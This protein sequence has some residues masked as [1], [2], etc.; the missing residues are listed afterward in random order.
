MIDVVPS[1]A[2]VED[3]LVR[4]QAL[5]V[6]RSFIVRA[7]AGSGK[8]RLLIQRYLGLLACVDEPEEIVAITFT[9]KAA[10]EMRERVLRAFAN[11]ELGV[12]EDD[13]TR[14]LALAALARDRLRGWQLAANPSRLR[15]QTI[16]ALNAS[17]TRQMPLAARFGAQP[18]SID[19]ASHLYDEAARALLAEI[20]GDGPV[21][22]DL[23]TL[24]FH[25]DNDLNIARNLVA[26]MLRSRDHWL[27]CLP[28]MHERESLEATLKRVRHGAVARAAALFPAAERDE[29][30]ELARFAGPK[31]PQVRAGGALPLDDLDSWPR[32]DEAAMPGWLALGD[33]LLTQAGTWRK[34]GGLNKNVGFPVGEGK[35]QKAEFAAA[36]DRMGALLERLATQAGGDALAS[37]LARL[38]E[39]P[40]ANYSEQQWEVLG[41]IVRLLPR[42][43]ALLWTVFGSQG[44]CDFTEISQSA[45]RALGPDEAPSDLALALDYRIRHLLVDEFQDTSFAQ[46][47]L[48][49]KLTRGWADG[50]GNTL[51]AVGDPM[52]SIYRFREAEVALFAEA[53]LRGIGGARLSVLGLCVNFRSDP[54]IVDWVNTTFSRLMPAD[55]DAASGRVPYAASRAHHPASPGVAAG[56]VLWHPTFVVRDNALD[57]LPEG[58]PESGGEAR[59]VIEIIQRTREQDNNA[60]IAILVRNRSHLVEIVPALKS[61]GIV[62]QAVD[63]DPLKDRPIVQDLLSLTR[64]LLHTADRIAW[65]AVLRAPWCGL[66]LQD[67]CALVGTA[68]AQ[69]S[70]LRP[71]ARTIVE[72]LADEERLKTLTAQGR[73]RVL[74]LRQVLM[75]ALAARRRLPLRE[76]VERTWLALGGAVCAQDVPALDDAAVVLALIE[77]EA[78]DQTGGTHLVDLER[79][80]VRVEKLY[81][82]NRAD[83]APDRPPPVQVMTIHKAKGLEFDT[84]ILPGLH[85]TPRRDDRR[86]LIWAE[87]PDSES[88]RQELIIA[89]IRETGASEELDAIYRYVQQLERDKQQEEDVR[90]L[91]VAATRAKRR[92]HLLATVTVGAGEEMSFSE[93]RASSLLSALWPV[94]TA[95]IRARFTAAPG[96]RDVP[97]PIARS[98]FR[99]RRLQ[100]D[101]VAPPLPPA[102]DNVTATIPLSATSAV[103]FEWAGEVARHVGTVVHGCLQRIAQDGLEM[104]GTDAVERFGPF[105][106][107]ELSH[108][109]VAVAE[110][111]AAQARVI[112]ALRR[113]LADERGRWVLERHREARSEWRLTGCTSGRIIDVAIDRT[114]V[115]SAGT[116]WIIDFKTGG[117][118]GGDKDRFLDNELKRYRAQLEQ[119]ARLVAALPQAASVPI[120]LALYFPLLSGWREWAWQPDAPP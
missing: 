64:A 65:L 14:S 100:L 39:L 115:D 116:R 50:D 95:E 56:E 120:R 101:Y 54:A 36:K 22:A 92:L 82:G 113:T 17:L 13:V 106:E 51:L 86:L 43:T 12:E 67:I 53:M 69:E 66:S 10:A 35:E 97:D 4:E 93:P 85:R 112:D 7:P 73:V 110:R 2:S 107:A 74:R 60:E 58:D 11:A 21:S 19:D 87:Q 5:D 34:R 99:A 31:C 44:Q 37:A 118:E 109:G 55:A 80:L 75:S 30:L 3:G 28:Q 20:D 16:D 61:A 15:I 119:Y 71:D 18:E 81:A 79:L 8:T 62:Y 27:R 1:V 26:Q 29:V 46:F 78:E 59:R 102:V 9:R 72:I 52:Q 98:I 77:A 38:R 49:A 63:I 6:G 108:L 111:V 24:L 105:A 33:F 32:T 45:V 41:A 48:L 103:D 40:P 68:Q 57:Q 70:E 76:L 96:I 91:Y 94:A 23:A 42:A 83:P 117:H 84:V 25:L 114:F 104:W 90:L 89:P 47:E 88:G